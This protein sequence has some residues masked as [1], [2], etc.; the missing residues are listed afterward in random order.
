[1]RSFALINMRLSLHAMATR[2][3]LVLHGED[4]VFLRA[5]GEEALQEIER[6]E[7]QLSFYRPDSEIA[8]LN[9]H[10]A[11]AP[12]LVSPRLF[13]ILDQCRQ[14]TALTDGAFDVTVGP[15]MRAW[16]FVREK[17]AVPAPE[18]LARAREP[19]GIS[20]LVFDRD[21]STI[22]F[23]L[24][25]VE[26]DLGGF[27]KGYAVEA[28]I[29]SLKDNGVTCALLHSGTSSVAVIGRPPD[30]DAWR[31]ELQE[32][33]KDGENPLRVGLLDN[34]LSVSAVHGKSFRV[35]EREYGHVIDPATGEPVE[36]ALAAAAI[37][38][39]ASVCEVLSTALLVKGPSWLPSCAARFPEYH[40]AVAFRTAES[41]IRTA[42]FGPPSI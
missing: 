20:H 42:H 14:Y 41:A 8:W 12:V 35:G 9:R 31:L 22:A 38:P 37:G 26:I 32:P 24:P 23:D 15:L 40:G 5:A 39:S 10:A 19:V 21:R 4:P 17:G 18:E 7:A 2:F 1:M 13:S 25:G 11:K 36:R 6:L 16:R 28:A 3:E 34:A 30:S 29:A 27:G 33:L